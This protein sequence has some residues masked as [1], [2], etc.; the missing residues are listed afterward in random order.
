MVTPGYFATLGNPVLR[1]RPFTDAD[2]SGAARVAALNQS[3]ARVLFGTRD[4][5]GSTLTISQAQPRDPAWEVVAI[6]RDVP[7]QGLGIDVRP[8][9]YLPLSQALTSIRGVTRA[10]S[11]AVRTSAEP[12]ALAPSLRGAIWELD[13]DLAV[14]NLE[15]M[16]TVVAASLAPQ[17]FQTA[18]TSTFAGLALALAAVGLYGLLAHLV[19]LRR[20][21][22]GIRLALGARPGT[23]LAQ[24]L[25][26]GVTVTCAGIAV[27]IGGAL[28]AGRAMRSVLYGVSPWDPV[29]LAATAG[30][31]IATAL[32]ASALPARRAA[33]VDPAVTLRGE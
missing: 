21:D 1:G 17:R 4:P 9:V 31:L 11:V 33:R 30:V 20:H 3:A 29:S 19:G 10:V 14:S 5:I 23:L 18:L 24:V 26:Q 6:V 22:L 27:G 12:R 7:T 13:R 32:A 25:R 15:P 8:Q 2:R 28:L 16:D